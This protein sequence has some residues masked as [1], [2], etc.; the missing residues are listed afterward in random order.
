[1]KVIHLDAAM[2]AGLDTDENTLKN[3]QLYAKRRK[4]DPTLVDMDTPN[5]SLLCKSAQEFVEEAKKLFN[6]TIKVG[7]CGGCIVDASQNPKK[8]ARIGPMMGATQKSSQWVCVTPP[9]APGADA[10]EFKPNH[11]FTCDEISF[12]HGFPT[13]A[14]LSPAR[15]RAC[16]NYDLSACS[17]GLQQR[18]LGDGMSI[19]AVSA[20]QLYVWAHT[21]RRAPFETIAPTLR[22]STLMPLS[23]LDLDSV[24]LP[25]VFPDA[26]PKNPENEPRART[27]NSSAVLSVSGCRRHRLTP[28]PGM[29]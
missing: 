25:P 5:L 19:H 21:V 27:P 26:E 1:M 12:M 16:L 11:L 17:L 13:S 3:K 24:E 22:C 7:V 18:I 23:R 2:F 29:F 6:L 15:H 10:A 4:L 14:Q 8:R 9:G 28:W 20:F